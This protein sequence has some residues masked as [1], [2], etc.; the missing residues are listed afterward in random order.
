MENDITNKIEQYLRQQREMYG[1]NL[2]KLNDKKVLKGTENA[3]KRVSEEEVVKAEI[4][5]EKV[6][7]NDEILEIQTPDDMK[8]KIK[9]EYPDTSGDDA[10]N[11]IPGWEMSRSLKE[12]KEQIEHCTKC[13]LHKTRTNFVF[14]TGNPKADIVVIGEAPGAEED[15]TGEPFVGQAGRML[16][17]ILESIE[18]SRDEVFICNI[19]KSRPPGNRR[20]TAEEVEACEPYLWKQ[21]ELIKPKFILALGLTAVNTLF[22]KTF[23]MGDIRGQLMD[24][25]GVQVLATYHPAALLRNPEWKRPV[26][27]DV[28]LLK[29]LY[30]D[31]K[32]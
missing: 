2:Y 5:E 25:H 31:S 17:K 21:L 13:P 29:K 12:L 20:P 11:V 23:K 18:L 30:E 16:T 4:N 28:Q 9:V 27:E 3:E 7:K 24:Y 26:W 10:F 1:E 32:K 6:L 8:K 15:A 14:G 19:I 22:K